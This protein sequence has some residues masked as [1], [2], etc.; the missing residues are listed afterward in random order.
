MR[1][2][3][4]VIDAANSRARRVTR[5]LG[6]PLDK[7]PASAVGLEPNGTAVVALGSV[8]AGEVAAID[9]QQVCLHSTVLYLQPF[10]IQS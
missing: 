5:A 6:S 4:N 7:P 3:S 9:M 2:V 10:M 1:K 8:A